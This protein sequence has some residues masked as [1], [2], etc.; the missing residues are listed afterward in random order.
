MLEVLNSGENGF[1]VDFFAPFELANCIEA[2]LY[3]P[4]EMKKIRATARAT[5]IQ[6]F[7]LK[8]IILPKWNKLFDDLIHHRRPNLHANV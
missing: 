1:V 4:K 7:D 5:T 8:K 3:S 2:A 6:H